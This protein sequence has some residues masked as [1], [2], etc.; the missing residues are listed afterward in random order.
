ML[1][2]DVVLGQCAE[3]GMID[4]ENRLRFIGGLGL[5]L[6]NRL[7]QH[8]TLQ[9]EGD[10]ENDWALDRVGLPCDQRRIDWSRQFRQRRTMLLLELIFWPTTRQE[11]VMK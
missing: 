2:K 7:F 5:G 11:S 4:Q 9:A 1:K 3:V 8:L 10:H 6:R